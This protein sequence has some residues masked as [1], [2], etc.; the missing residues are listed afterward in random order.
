MR[1][2]NKIILTCLASGPLIY[3]AYDHAMHS[4]TISK[5]RMHL[6]Y[7]KPINK[8]QLKDYPYVQNAAII[9]DLRAALTSDK[10]GVYVLCAPPGSG[11]STYILNVCHDLQQEKKIAGFL[12]F[13][14]SDRLKEKGPILKRILDR[15]NIKADFLSDVI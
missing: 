15:Y 13:S 12:D 9:N 7:T 2:L 8:F 5:W 4:E 11:K 3:E 6:R 14:G 10:M 1:T